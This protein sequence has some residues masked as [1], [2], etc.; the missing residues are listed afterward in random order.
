MAF[1][2]LG[3][4]LQADVGAVSCGIRGGESGYKIALF[5]EVIEQFTAKRSRGDQREADE[6]G[7]HLVS[8]AVP[9]NRRYRIG[10]RISVK[11]VEESRPP[12][13]TMASGRWISDPGPVAN[14]SGIRPK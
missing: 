14:K 5:A 4:C 11:A 2:L 1:D 7:T 9:P 13:T 3:R 12:I 6:L 10:R 8:F